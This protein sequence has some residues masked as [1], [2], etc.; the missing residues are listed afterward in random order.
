MK[1]FS[2]LI[3]GKAGDGIDRAGIIIARILNRLGN[4]ICMYRD[5]P[6]LI[7][8]GHTFSIIRA[9]ERPIGAHM[10]KV[11][12]VVALNQE[13]ADL[14][15]SRLKDRS[16]VMIFDSDSVT[17]QGMGIPAGKIVKDENGHPLTRNSCMIGAMCRAAGIEWS[18]VEEVFRASMHHELEINLK[19]AR[20]GF[21]A[22]VE[23]VRAPVLSGKPL[24][25]LT[26]NDAVSL[27][28][29]KGGLK[30]YLAYPMTPAS[31]IL[32]TLADLSDEFGLKVVH[33]ENEIAV[34]LMAT[35]FAYAG[36][37][38]AVG[39]SGGGFCL[40]VEGLSF[41][42][43][44]EIPVVV[45]LGQ[46][47]G[48]STGLPTY[49]G[50][51]ELNF[52]LS[53]GHGDM[54]RLVVAPGDLEESFYWSAESLNLAWKYQL[55]VIILGDKTLSEGTFSFDMD[56]VPP[57]S[58]KIPPGWDGKAQ[59]KRYAYTPTGVSPLAF[60]P[61]KDAIIKIDSYEH[62]EFGV[63]IEDP[64]VTARMQEKRLRKERFLLEE[65]EANA[66]SVKVLGNASAE[67]AILTWGSNK[68]A[69]VEVGEKLGLRV[70]HVAA[71][72]PLPAGRF[73]EAVKGVKRLLCV[74]CNATGQLA[75]HVSNH[76]FKVDGKI[77][78][79]DGRPFSADGLEEDIRKVL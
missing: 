21:D 24:P 16:S 39:S 3:G 71:I 8:G 55:P 61:A 5:Y 13:T 23:A 70:V 66:E 38:V 48:P 54:P 64:T 50:Q 49:T 32:H 57:V 27:G 51:T 36:Q 29:I 15:A 11:D 62:D 46:R 30:A 74:E 35:G 40:M 47:T 56:A 75:K 79:Y 45:F 78:R 52:A 7:R 65:L 10:E 42:G 12:A 67:T 37:R 33:P 44:A 22:A 25:L 63:T 6:S 34:M 60:P 31:S 19:I 14:H 59:Y 4:R 2:I 18:I 53:A 73:R 68:G 41:S 26:G 20:R 9:A 77:L 72:S 76:G 69:C 17:A 58:E 43:A 28:L 1:D